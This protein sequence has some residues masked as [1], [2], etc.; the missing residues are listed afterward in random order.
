M[1]ANI[2][3]RQAIQEAMEEADDYSYVITNEQ[4]YEKR[5]AKEALSN[6]Y[7]LL[8]DSDYE[9]QRDIRQRESEEVD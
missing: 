2:S 9:T 7:Y 5:G 1:G 4:V 3:V 8:F 6:L